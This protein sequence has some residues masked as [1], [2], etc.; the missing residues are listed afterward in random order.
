MLEFSNMAKDGKEE[1][2]IKQFEQIK[3][4]NKFKW[5]ILT[6]F[7]NLDFFRIDF[8]FC[9]IHIAVYIHMY[10]IANFF[11]VDYGNISVH[12]FQFLHNVWLK[13]NNDALFMKNSRNFLSKFQMK[14][15][16]LNFFFKSCGLICH[17]LK[18]IIT[19]ELTIAW[20]YG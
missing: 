9:N 11:P 10:T 1:L 14:F 3:Y 4:L 13:K 16:K 20:G 17:A 19:Y 12:S 8:V 5:N 2:K 18:G 6:N 7:H 15:L